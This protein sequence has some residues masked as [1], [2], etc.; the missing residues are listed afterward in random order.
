[1]SKKTINKLTFTQR[2]HLI[3]KKMFSGDFTIPMY[4]PLY[5]EKNGVSIVHIDGEIGKKLS[6]IDKEEGKVDVDDICKALKI[7]EKANTHCVVLCINSPGGASTGIEETGNAIK[8]L[9]DTKAVFTFTDTMCASAAMWLA[10]CTNGIFIT[11]S[12]EVGSIGVFAKVI[13]YS[14]SL[15]MQGIN[16]QTFSAGALKTM[17]SGDRPLDENESKIIQSDINEQW[18]KFKSLVRDNRGEIKEENMQ[19]QLFEGQK[20]V[21]ANLAD[22][23]VADYDTFFEKISTVETL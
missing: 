16:I 15:K 3:A 20:A 14:E 7:A 23:V 18:E 10:S 21:D 9:T 4:S 19:G 8:R 12:S 2:L 5:E 1:M 11:P 6:S 17:G 13:D 22:E